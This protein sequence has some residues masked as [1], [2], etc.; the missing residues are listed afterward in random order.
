MP[1][2]SKEDDGL[3]I[4]VSRERYLKR[5]IPRCASVHVNTWQSLPFLLCLRISHEN[6]I[7]RNKIVHFQSQPQSAKL[8]SHKHYR[9]Y[10]MLDS[11]VCLWPQ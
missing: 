5:A 4:L 11:I 3:V 9:L 8:N 10:G 1:V 7:V 6:N 2:V